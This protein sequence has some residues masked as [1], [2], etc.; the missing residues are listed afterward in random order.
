MKFCTVINCMDGRT[1]IP[2]IEYLKQ[3]F[4]VQYVDSI[5]EP[6]PNLI[7]AQKDDLH[8][9]QSILKRLSISIKK[10]GSQAIAIVGHYDCAGNPAP[11]EEQ[12]NHIKEAIKFIKY[13]YPDKEVI[14]L[15][16]NKDWKVK[17][18]K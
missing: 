15:W 7:L 2:V 11:K 4:K 12:I 18:V 10:H 13:Y 8:S 17:E 9:V 5:T 1:Q 6:G 3:R 16:V 14:G